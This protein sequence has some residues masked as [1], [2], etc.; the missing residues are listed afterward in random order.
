MGVGVVSDF[1]PYENGF[2]MIKVLE[3]ELEEERKKP[4]VSDLLIELQ[5]NVHRPKIAND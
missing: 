2:S 5:G 4:K 1:F 3:K